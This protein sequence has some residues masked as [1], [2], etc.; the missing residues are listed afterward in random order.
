VLAKFNFKTWVL[1]KSYTL[2]FYRQ[3]SFDK[4]EKRIK[5]ISFQKCIWNMTVW[6]MKEQWH[7]PPSLKSFEWGENVDVINIEALMGMGQNYVYSICN[8]SRTPA[9]NGEAKW[10]GT[11]A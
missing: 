10:V 3:L 7:F 6:N 1:I 2:L 4:N 11:T 9:R 5:W 8:R